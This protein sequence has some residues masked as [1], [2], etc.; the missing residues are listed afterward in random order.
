MDEKER[1][2]RLRAEVILKVQSGLITAKEG[3]KLLGVS[4]KTYYQW[5]KKGL[6]GLMGSLLEKESGRKPKKTDTEKEALKEENDALKK[7]VNR[8]RA[9]LHIKKVMEPENGSRSGTGI[10]K[11]E[12]DAKKR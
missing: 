3:A 11:K 1:K 9:S 10:E 12:K 6:S 7:E 5:E 2:A 8:L 4:R